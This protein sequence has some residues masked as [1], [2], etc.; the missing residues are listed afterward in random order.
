MKINLFR[1]VFSPAVYAGILRRVAD[2]DPEDNQSAVGESRHSW[3]FLA[4]YV[5]IPISHYPT[6]ATCPYRK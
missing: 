3:R 2:A 1:S 5:L 6:C 4:Q